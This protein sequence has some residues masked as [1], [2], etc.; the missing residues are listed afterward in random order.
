MQSPLFWRSLSKPYTR[1]RRSSQ[2]SLPTACAACGEHIRRLCKGRCV[3]SVRWFVIESGPPTAFPKAAC[4]SPSCEDSRDPH[5][6]FVWLAWSSEFPQQE[7]VSS[8]RTRFAG[9]EGSMSM[10]DLVVMGFYSFV[11]L[12]AIGLV[13]LLTAYRH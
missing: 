12:I 4:P 13:V 10:L 2:L 5:G 8:E 1:W 11:S 3:F 7:T 6:R 9:Q